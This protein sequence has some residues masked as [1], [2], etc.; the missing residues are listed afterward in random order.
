MRVFVLFPKAACYERKDTVTQRKLSSVFNDNLKMLVNAGATIRYLL[1][2]KLAHEFIQKLNYDKV[3]CVSGIPK[4]DYDY[5]MRHQDED[6]PIEQ[7]FYTMYDIV[8]KVD[9][10]IGLK[11]TVDP[12][13]FITDREAA[14]IQRKN[15]YKRRRRE[16]T[17]NLVSKSN[18]VMV[19]RASN[20]TDRS[21]NAI[22]TVSQGDGRLVI[23]VDL[24]YGNVSCYYGGVFIPADMIPNI[25]T[26]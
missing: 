5:I 22:D 15:C 4:T 25:L 11:Y 13:L 21:L 19:F 14:L 20:M 9:D 7:Y 24:T 10:D 12:R 3:E 8:E 1:E 16:I 17:D 23:Q 26:L 2:D 6:D 18:N